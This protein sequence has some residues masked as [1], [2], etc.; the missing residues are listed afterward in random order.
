MNKVRLVVLCLL[1]CVVAAC[2]SAPP[3]PKGPDLSGEWILT[4]DT[5]FGSQDSTMTVAQTG[6][7]L[8]GKVSSEMGSVDYTGTLTGSAIAFGFSIE[9]QG[10]ELRLDYSGT[11]EG[12]TMKGKT[13][14]GSFG[15]GT[16]TAKRKT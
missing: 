11:V 15:E 6:Q 13:V 7:A 16:F 14:L 3:K 8:A 4:T 5:Q 1:A 2:A 10:T 12:D 9:V